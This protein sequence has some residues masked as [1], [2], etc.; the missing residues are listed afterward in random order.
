[1]LPTSARRERTSTL[2]T[3]AASI[4]WEPEIEHYTNAQ[5]ADLNSYVNNPFI[6]PAQSN[7]SQLITD[8]NNP[9]LANSQIQK[10][11]LLMPHP[12]FFGFSG[13]EPP[14]ANSIYH[15]LQVRAE[16]RFSTRLGI[17]RNL[18]LLQV[19]RRCLVDQHQQRATWEVLPACRIRTIP[20]VSAVSLRSTFPKSCS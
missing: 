15:A 16:K 17:P 20:V 2:P 12:Q 6:D 11:Q 19:H 4:T 5:I 7:A 3:P 9:L 10:L 1:M 8:P 14:I 18:H 13:D